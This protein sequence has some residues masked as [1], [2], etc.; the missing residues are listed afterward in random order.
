MCVTGGYSSS[1]AQDL[2]KKREQK[3]SQ[4]TMEIE[5]LDKKHKHSLNS[6]DKIKL[7]GKRMELQAVLDEE[8]LKIKG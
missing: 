3:K 7:K 6:L 2:K 5:K 1:M 8:F 4:L